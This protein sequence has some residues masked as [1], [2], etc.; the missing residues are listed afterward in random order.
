MTQVHL[1]EEQEAAD[2]EPEPEQ[3]DIVR[4]FLAPNLTAIARIER[5]R[6]AW[7]AAALRLGRR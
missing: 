5:E 2:L 1:S 4:L 7:N 3:A 6:L